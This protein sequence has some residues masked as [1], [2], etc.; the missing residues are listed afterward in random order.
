MRDSGKRRRRRE[1]EAAS[2]HESSILLFQRRTLAGG[3]RAGIAT[4][5]THATERR[6]SHST[7]VDAPDEG[8][9]EPAGQGRHAEGALLPEDAAYLPAGQDTQETD[10]T[11][12]AVR[13]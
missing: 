12:A 3:I 4:G 1:G 11:E 10:E 7:H 5:V 2:K 8:A 9:Y 6:T 13:E